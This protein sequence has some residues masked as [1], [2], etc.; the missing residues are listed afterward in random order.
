MNTAD[1][2][3]RRVHENAMTDTTII[4]STLSKNGDTEKFTQQQYFAV[5]YKLVIYT[6]TPSLEVSGQWRPQVKKPMM[7]TIKQDTCMRHAH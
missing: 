6:I 3:F 1:N 2:R 7:C 5:L 4:L